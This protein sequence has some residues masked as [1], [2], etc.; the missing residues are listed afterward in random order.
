VLPKLHIGKRGNKCVVGISQM[1]KRKERCCQA[2]EKI[3]RKK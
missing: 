2:S 3:E 1:R